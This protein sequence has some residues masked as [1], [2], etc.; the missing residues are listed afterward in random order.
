MKFMF[1]FYLLLFSYYDI[2]WEYHA[3]VLAYQNKVKIG[4][5]LKEITIE[6][7]EMRYFSFAVLEIQIANYISSFCFELNESANIY[8]MSSVKNKCFWEKN[9]WKSFSFWLLSKLTSQRKWTVQYLHQWL[10]NK[11][12]IL[13]IADASL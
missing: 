8:S 11:L 5:I 2:R 9:K 4:Y 3:G 10:T 6:M 1:L 7:H 12:F 13:N